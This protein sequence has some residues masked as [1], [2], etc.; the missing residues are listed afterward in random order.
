MSSWT[1]AQLDAVKEAIASGALK[2]K[3][4]D[5]EVTYRSTDELIRLKNEMEKDL[6][7]KSK[8]MTRFVGIYDKGIE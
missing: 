8:T 6:G 4:Q 7:T 2:V 3:Y 1:Q 5:K